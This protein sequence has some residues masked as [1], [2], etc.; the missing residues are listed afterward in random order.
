MQTAAIPYASQGAVDQ[1]HD[2]QA[3]GKGDFHIGHFADMADYLLRFVGIL[4]HTAVCVKSS[5]NQVAL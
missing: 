5:A 3:G 4:S 1:S 2:A